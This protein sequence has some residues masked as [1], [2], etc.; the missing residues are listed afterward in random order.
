MLPDNYIELLSFAIHDN[1]ECFLARSGCRGR[2]YYLYKDALVR[3]KDF[4]KLNVTCN[5][6]LYFCKGNKEQDYYFASKDTIQ[7]IKRDILANWSSSITC[8]VFV[9]GVPN[10]R[11]RSGGL[12]SLPEFYHQKTLGMTNFIPVS[13]YKIDIVSVFEKQ[14]G[15]PRLGKNILHHLEGK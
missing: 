14:V 6:A 5:I 2:E 4:T 3:I 15:F 11:E 13:E 9:D 8:N 1:G 10:V 12:I 7:D